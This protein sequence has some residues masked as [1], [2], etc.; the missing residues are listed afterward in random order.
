MLGSLSGPVPVS[1]F[2]ALRTLLTFLVRITIIS[3]ILTVGGLPA[4][5]AWV[6]GGSV[7]F[8]HHSSRKRLAF[9]SRSLTHSPEEFRR[10][11]IL[12]LGGVLPSKTRF[13]FHHCFE[14]RGKVF[15]LY[16]TEAMYFYTHQIKFD[17]IFH[18]QFCT[19][20][21]PEQCVF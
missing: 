18:T 12:D 2:S 1:T 9:A 19:P 20:G 7:N 16:L 14:Q 5:G 13:N 8:A 11:G 15:I 21:S 17:C 10:D 3:V 6:S 4:L